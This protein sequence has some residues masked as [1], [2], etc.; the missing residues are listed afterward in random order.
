MGD[1]HG[2]R[3]SYNLYLWHAAVAHALLER[4]IP[5]WHG[6]DQHADAGWGLA[7]TFAAAAAALGVASLITFAIERPLLR[8]RPFAW[9]FAHLAAR[10]EAFSRAGWR[11]RHLRVVWAALAAR[12]AAPD[13]P[14][15]DVEKLP[16]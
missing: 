10:A 3:H 14:S 9:E 1:V 12:D 13:S 16:A 11:T 8:A 4:R 15:A 2:S 6:A 5:G 7:F